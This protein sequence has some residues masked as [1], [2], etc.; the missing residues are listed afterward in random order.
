[1]ST[2]R[3]REWMKANPDAAKDVRRQNR[4]VVFFR[5]VGLTD[6]EEARGA[7]GIPLSPGPP[8]RLTAQC[9]STVRRFSSKRT[10]RST[11]RRTAAP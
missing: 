1:M 6:D 11:A 4:S 9:M 7:Q 8:S 5:V 2:R 3:I 10:C